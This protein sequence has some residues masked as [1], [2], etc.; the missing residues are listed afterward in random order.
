MDGD[1]VREIIGAIEMGTTPP[2]IEPD[3]DNG[4]IPFAVILR[5]GNTQRV[6]SLKDIR[7]ENRERPERMKGTANV[8][9][10]DSFNELVNRHKNDQAS[11]IFADT[12]SAAPSLLGVLNYNTVGQSPGWRDHRVAF[13]FP[14]SKEWKEWVDACATGKKFTQPDF[15]AFLLLN[16][17]YLTSPTSEE[18]QLAKNFGTTCATPADLLQLGKGLEL[19]INAVSK[20]EVN[21]RTG[22]KSIVFTEEQKDGQGQKLAVPGLFIIRIPMFLGDSASVTRVPVHLFFRRM[23][24]GQ[25]VW[26]MQMHMA[27]EY[28]RSA[29]LEGVGR[30]RAATN[31]PIIEGTPES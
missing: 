10:I 1:A 12:L 9:T 13:K 11:I 8:Q 16:M 28:L 24:T 17:I 5:D 6:V 19:H 30:V 27:D 21:P 26:W 25:I 29:V 2:A 20:E 22:E 23:G 15:G 18:E 3:E 4:S 31:L 14:L 7:D